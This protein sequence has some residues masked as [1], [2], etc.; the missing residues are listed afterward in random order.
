MAQKETVPIEINSTT[1]PLDLIREIKGGIYIAEEHTIRNMNKYLW[2]GKYYHHG[3]TDASL[4]MFERLDR[5]YLEIMK[6][7]ELEKLDAEKERAIMDIAR[8]AT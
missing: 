2:R 7:A 8:N 5:S 1:L 6:V 3:K 4:D